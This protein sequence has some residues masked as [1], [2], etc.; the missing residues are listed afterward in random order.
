LTEDALAVLDD[1][2]TGKYHNYKHEYQ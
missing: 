1:V 2:E